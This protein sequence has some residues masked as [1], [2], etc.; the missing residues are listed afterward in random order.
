MNLYLLSQICVIISICI[1]SATYFLKDKGKILGLCLIYCI[2]YGIH[3]L[4][5]GAITGTCMNLVSF[6]RNYWFYRN[7]KKKKKNSELVLYTLFLISSIFCIISYDD[8]FSLVSLTASMLSTYSIWQDNVKIYKFIAV[9]VSICFI[10]YAIHINS[11]VAVITEVV[12]LIAEIIA[13]IKL[14]MEQKKLEYCIDNV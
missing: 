2:F 4:L 6:I 1:M 3:Y 7:S 10:I 12:L 14:S 9:P 13:I 8:V 5:L 11:I